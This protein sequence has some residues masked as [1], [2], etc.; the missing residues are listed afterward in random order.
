MSKNVCFQLLWQLLDKT[1]NSDMWGCECLL[2]HTDQPPPPPAVLPR[3]TKPQEITYTQHLLVAL[4][5]KRQDTR[6]R[7]HLFVLPSAI[8]VLPDMIWGRKSRREHEEP[9]R[10]WWLAW[11]GEVS[12]SYR[13]TIWHFDTCQRQPEPSEGPR[14]KIQQLMRIVHTLKNPHGKYIRSIER[15]R[16]EKVTNGGLLLMSLF[17]TI[18]WMGPWVMSQFCNI[19]QKAT[20]PNY[21][22]ARQSH[23]G[24]QRHRAQLKK[25]LMIPKGDKP[26][27]RY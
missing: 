15:K 16:R 13:P 1:Q 3:F 18:A 11:A 9:L 6:T 26:W 19:A 20:L 24:P 12:T 4:M 22:Q 14:K 5:C 23:Q 10:D 17:C 25:N 7:R 8:W 2:C 21:S 27:I